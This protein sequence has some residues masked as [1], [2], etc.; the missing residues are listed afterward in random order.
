MSHKKL[1]R[2]ALLL[3]LALALPSCRKPV[4]AEQRQEE[5]VTVYS[6]GYVCNK[7][8]AHVFHTSLKHPN[9]LC[10][11][12]FMIGTMHSFNYSDY[13]NPLSTYLGQRSDIKR[14]HKACKDHKK[15][16]LVG[17]SRGAS[18]IIN[19]LGTYKPTNI[20]AAIVESPFDNFENVAENFMATSRVFKRVVTPK[21]KEK[22]K[23]FCRRLLFRNYRPNETQPINV[24][25]DVPK[26][27]PLLLISSD[28][29]TLIPAQSTKNIY[30]VL[31]K[32][33]HTKAY[34]LPCKIGSHGRIL[35][36]QE[37]Q[38]FRNVVHAFYKHHNVPHHEPWAQKGY[39]DFMQC[40]GVVEK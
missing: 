36:G 28:Q 39:A 20:I 34:L 18:T 25:P 35:W 4:K 1:G 24:A 32:S 40:S 7:L 14:L 33:G 15:V 12:A 38:M 37:G 5:V 30:D 13:L 23:H 3:I 11:N 9:K 26:D 21:N 6:H 22:I 2:L 29:D 19:Y 10:A 27:I 16:I 17:V 8:I 31:R